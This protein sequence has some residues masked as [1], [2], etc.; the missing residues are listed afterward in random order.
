MKQLNA[1]RMAA[2]SYWNKGTY[3]RERLANQSWRVWTIP[4]KTPRGG[5][6]LLQDFESL[7]SIVS[8]LQAQDGQAFCLD[9]ITIQ[10]RQLGEQRLPIHARFESESAWL[11][12]IGKTEEA[13]QFDALSRQILE[14][15]PDLLPVLIRSPA[16]V[17][18]YAAVWPQLLRIFAWFMQNPQSGL[19]LRQIDLPG[20][21]SKFI[22]QHKAVLSTLLDPSYR[23][24][25]YH[26]FERRYGLRFEEP[27]I[28]FRLLDSAL[29]GLDDLSVPASQFA[30]LRFPVESVFITENKAN[31]LAFPAHPRAM[32]I[33][34]LGYGLD[35]LF[36]AD[37]LSNVA[38]YYWGDL[39]THGFAMLARLRTHFSHTQ[40]FL[41]DPATLKAHWASQIPEPKPVTR[42]MPAVL[43]SDEIETYKQLKLPDG[44]F[45]RIEQERIGYHWIEAAL[46]AQHSSFNFLGSDG[47]PKR[48]AFNSPELEL[49]A[50]K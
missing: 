19:Y 21:D 3:H 48:L 28:R 12:F 43:T 41:M 27:S 31:G 6:A 33:F 40:S 11:D 23:G 37:W 9:W 44:K 8:D 38:I 7:R 39:D 45:A 16:I 36:L 26:G 35:S 47:F 30:A 15:Q 50:R 22:E 42:E 13:K 46:R 20:I 17:L 25:A 4:L 18:E 5:R 1:L 32:V 10:H 2:Y 29:N 49:Q 34:G 24:L 14:Q